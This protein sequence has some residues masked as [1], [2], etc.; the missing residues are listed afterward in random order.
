MYV[1]QNTEPHNTETKKRGEK[2]TPVNHTS[3]EEKSVA[4]GRDAKMREKMKG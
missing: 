2:K 3:E 1:C 4:L